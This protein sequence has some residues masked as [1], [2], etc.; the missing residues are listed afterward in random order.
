[1]ARRHPPFALALAGSERLGRVVAAGVRGDTAALARL[2]LD[3]QQACGV[4]ERRGYR[5]HLTV[6]SGAP[7]HA[8]QAYHGP[9]FA[10]TRLE[11]VHSVLGRTAVHTT[12]AT[13]PL[14]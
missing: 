8:L 3:V 7:P 10:V 6:G 13:V 12:L 14:G 9:S 2:A 11:L 5:P 1:V 4:H